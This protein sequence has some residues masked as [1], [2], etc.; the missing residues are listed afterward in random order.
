MR[1]LQ[2]VAPRTVAEAVELL[3]KLGPQATVVAG[4]TDVVVALNERAILP[5]T[6]VSIDRLEEL[7]FVREEQGALVIGALI[8]MAEL[9][10][11]PVVKGK[12]EVLAEAAKQAAGPPVRNLGTIGGNLATASPA[13]DL[14]AA[15]VALDAVVVLVGADGTREV[16]VAGFCR[17]AQ[18]QLLAGRGAHQGGRDPWFRRRDRLGVPEAGQ[19]QGHVHLRGECRGCRDAFRPMASGSR[20]SG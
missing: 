6:L 10:A 2:Y 12:A 8:T 13:G 7:R 20:R 5:G 17:G 11:S 15:L 18:V 3:A 16:P 4:G 9:A 14:I 1:D 19:A